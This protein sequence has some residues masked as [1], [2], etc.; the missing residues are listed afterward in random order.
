MKTAKAILWF[1][2]LIASGLVFSGC[3]KL[4]PVADKTRFYVL[5]PLQATASST[6]ATGEYL[7]IGIGRIDIPDYLQRKQIAV[8]KASNEIQYSETFHWAERLDKGIQRVL[9]ANFAELLGSTNVVLSA[10]GPNSV[11]A[12]VYVSVQRFESNDQGRVVLEARWRI[13]NLGAG[14][15]CGSGFSTITKQGPSPATDPDGTV[16]SMGEALGDLSREIA[17]A[18][19][20]LSG[21]RSRS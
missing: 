3:V 20:V 15:T 19:R 7:A 10:G 16:A 4:Q 13:A 2:F 11:Q 1:A 21:S 17:A 8:R 12:E 6:P 9:G 5:S 18:L 14:G